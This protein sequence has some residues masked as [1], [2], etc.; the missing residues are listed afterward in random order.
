MVIT[1]KKTSSAHTVSEYRKPHCLD[2]T[3][4]VHRV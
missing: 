2:R 4:P 1:A 3:L